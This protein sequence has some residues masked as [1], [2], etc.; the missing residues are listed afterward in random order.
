MMTP[1]DG[2]VVADREEPIDFDGFH[3]E[4]EQEV[5][6]EVWDPA[7]HWFEPLDDT[8]SSSSDED[9]GGG[10]NYY[11]WTREDVVIPEE[12]WRP[13]CFG[14]FA[15]VRAHATELG[16]N[17]LSVVQDFDDCWSGVEY[18]VQRLHEC[19]SPGRPGTRIVTE[20][21]VDLPTL[22]GVSIGSFLL[23]EECEQL[24]IDVE[25]TGTYGYIQVLLSSGDD[26]YQLDCVD[27]GGSGGSHTLTC[28]VP[29]GGPHDI[30]ESWDELR[31]RI[32]EGVFSWAPWQIQVRGLDQTTCEGP[33]WTEWMGA[34][35]P[36]IEADG[37][38]EACHIGEGPEEPMPPT[39]P[40][41]VEGT[42]WNVVCICQDAFAQVPVDVELCMDT[43]VS[44][45]VTGASLSCG[46]AANE[47]ERV[48][49]V[50]TD[51][52]LDALADTDAG[53]CFPGHWSIERVGM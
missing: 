27:D 46:W 44:M 26:D 4:A 50:E 24:T 21:F 19:V 1:W 36:G 20:G 15:I 8:L 47:I 37:S 35:S 3:V 38:S 23:V 53:P 43:R 45:P 5:L 42:W 14:E 30:A 25:V 18:D 28:T 11:R 52:V 34:G 41:D 49:G 51:C 12:Y 40:S 2:Y 22:G 33:R 6:I 29:F 7:N 48:T 9:V 10:H 16:A 31:E 13:G 17:L 32:A 39:D